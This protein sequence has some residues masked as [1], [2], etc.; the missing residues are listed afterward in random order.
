MGT[1]A[2][3]IIATTITAAASLLVG[4]LT[5]RSERQELLSTQYQAL[6][7]DMQAW[8]QRQ[9]EERDRLGAIMQARLDERISELEDQVAGLRTTVDV[10]KRKYR[11]AVTHIRAWRAMHPDRQ[12]EAPDE[13]AE[14]VLWDA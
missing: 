9:L 1:A 4:L 14:D 11:A 5:R 10:L 6:V 3:G 2:I 7:D 12:P 8:T 13:I